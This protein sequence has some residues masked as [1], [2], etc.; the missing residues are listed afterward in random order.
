MDVE[1]LSGSNKDEEL[2][3][4]ELLYRHIPLNE[5]PTFYFSSRAERLFVESQAFSARENKSGPFAG[6]IELSVDQARLRDFQPERTWGLGEDGSPAPYG[7]ICFSAGLAR[8]VPGVEA[9]VASP[10]PGN[11]AHALIRYADFSF[12]NKSA[13]RTALRALRAGL[14]DRVNA[15]DKSPWVVLPPESA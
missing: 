10:L 6:R 7:V 8:S 1:E 11:P 13:A 2:E 5:P 14:A 15:Q 9:V 3:D 4:E 12:L